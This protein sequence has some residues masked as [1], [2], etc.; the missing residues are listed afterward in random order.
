MRLHGV[1][2]GWD[3]LIQRWA[4]P[5]LCVDAQRRGPYRLWHH[6]HELDATADGRTRM[7]DTVRY[8]IGFGLLGELAHRA[9]V[10]RDVEAIFAFRAE[11][12]PALLAAH[13]H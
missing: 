13:P 9:L 8:A 6:T 2:V 7:R 5:R 10:R 11:R 4:P 1:P 3:T 12:I